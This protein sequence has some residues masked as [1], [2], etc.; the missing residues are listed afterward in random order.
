MVGARHHSY[1]ITINSTRNTIWSSVRSGADTRSRVS[2]LG[3]RIRLPDLLSERVVRLTAPVS[4]T[5]AA[6]I[7][8]RV[9]K[10]FITATGHRCLR[11]GFHP[12]SRSAQYCCRGQS[13]GTKQ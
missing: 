4:A 5:A 7:K 3:I 9:M 13:V 2:Y 6:Q 12:G 11:P 10:M 1:L 8:G